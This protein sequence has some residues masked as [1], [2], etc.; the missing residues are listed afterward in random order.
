MALLSRYSSSTD[1]TSSSPSSH[2]IG[3]PMKTASRNPSKNLSTIQRSDQKLRPFW[4]DTEVRPTRHPHHRVAIPY[5][6]HGKQ[7]LETHVK[8]WERSNGR[9]KVMFL[10]SRYWSSTDYTSSS[11]SSHSIAIPMKTASRN[12]YKIW[13]RSNGRTKSYGPFKPILKVAD[14]TSF[15]LNIDSTATRTKTASGN[16]SKILRA[17]KQSDQKLWPFWADTQGWGPDILVTE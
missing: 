9:T 8:I 11:P 10:L 17:I 4:P 5:L 2:S 7:P 1:H 3:T 12:H 6:P 15:S 13:A 14:Q 16:R